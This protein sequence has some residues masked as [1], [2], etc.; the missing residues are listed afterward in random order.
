MC[1]GMCVRV[2][3]WQGMVCERS[4]VWMM[5]YGSVY[6]LHESSV[7]SCHSQVSYLAS[8]WLAA[9]CVTSQTANIHAIVKKA[10]RCGAVYREQ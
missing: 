3:G 8:K 5:V 1:R 4:V 6:R 2:E 9:A 10:H 7:A